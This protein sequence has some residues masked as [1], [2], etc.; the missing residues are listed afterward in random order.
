VARVPSA[1]EAEVVAALMRSC[2][3]EA[4]VAEGGRSRPTSVGNRVF[5]HSK[6]A[7]LAREIL[8][9]PPEFDDDE[10]APAG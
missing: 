6:D 8:A 5:V 9:A 4:A 3:I 2:G 10:T 1:A 7:E